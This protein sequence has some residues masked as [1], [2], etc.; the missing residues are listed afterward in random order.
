MS[1]EKIEVGD[2][3]KIVCDDGGVANRGTVLTVKTVEPFEDGSYD[4]TFENNDTGAWG[5][6]DPEYFE[7][8]G[9]EKSDGGPAFPG[10]SLRDYFAAK[11]MQAI[12]SDFKISDKVREDGDF[13]D[14]EEYFEFIIANSAYRIADAMLKER[15][16]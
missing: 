12:C 3:L 2:K 10:M 9:P 5:Y 11:A 16:K 6:P 4:I 1:R 8:V 7:Y 13:D 15:S 14:E